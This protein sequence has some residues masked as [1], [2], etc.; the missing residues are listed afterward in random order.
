VS[1]DAELNRFVLLNDRLF[2]PSF[3]K[4]V[5]D[6]LGKTSLLLI[7][8]EMHRYMKWI[9]INFMGISRLKNHFL[10]DAERCI[11]QIL[12]SWKED[13]PFSAK[14][15]AR[16]VIVQK[17]F[18]VLVSFQFLIEFFLL[19]VAF[20]LMVKNILSMTPG[21][22]ETEQLRKLYATFMKGM[23]AF[24]LNVPGTAYRKALQVLNFPS[25]PSLHIYGA[26]G[27]CS[28]YILFE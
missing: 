26:I 3:P 28:T 16:K 8:G 13:T 11:T 6:I 20:N 25:P 12:N 27:K 7:S 15:E 18:Y 1:S 2:E 9:V 19:Q 21:E 17:T 22:P 10:E 4:S 23:L 24:P 14:D 5:E